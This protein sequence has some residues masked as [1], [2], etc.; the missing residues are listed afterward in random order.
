MANYIPGHLFQISKQQFKLFKSLHH[1][2]SL[3]SGSPKTWLSW[4]KNIDNNMRLAF[5]DSTT[6]SQIQSV[7]SNCLASLS[8]VAMAHY[9]S[10]LN[11]A[12][13]YLLANLYKMSDH[14]L[15]VSH[16]Q[17]YRW[18]SSQLG[19]KFKDSTWFDGLDIIYSL[20]KR[21]V[22]N[23]QLAASTVVPQQP[24]ASTLMPQQPAASTVVPQQPAVSTVVCQ[25]PAVNSAATT[26]VTQTEDAV[27]P[28]LVSVAN[29]TSPQLPDSSRRF[30]MHSGTALLPEDAE[31][32]RLFDEDPNWF[33]SQS[34]SNVPMLQPTVTL[35]IDDAA[36]DRS[37]AAVPIVSSASSEPL[38]SHA[39]SQPP[40]SQI[41]ATLTSFVGGDGGSAVISTQMEKISEQ[42]VS[43]RAD[44]VLL[45]DSNWKNFSPPEALKDSFAIYLFSG[46]ISSA[47]TILDKVNS[48]VHLKK[49]ILCIGCDNF[50]ADVKYILPFIGHI[51]KY[52]N[53][54]FNRCKIFISL[55]GI[56]NSLT[57]N[58][59]LALES[60]NN[61]LRSKL[62]N[63]IFISAP[64]NFELVNNNFSAET[65]ISFYNQVNSFLR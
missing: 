4:M 32:I 22:Q 21:S 23:I 31:L 9:N 25:Q 5:A 41:Q 50:S 48:P 54:K 34:Q 33:S 2:R 15:N 13:E 52:L 65:K 58:N 16:N 56:C 44:T 63:V 27:H 47:K 19:K 11:S 43:T 37:T 6:K 45:G 39:S 30:T 59:K 29:Q 8:S 35:P 49:L 57:A 17:V 7:T 36:G 26:S 55:I 38:P 3:Q 60:L 18:C 1:I 14:Y 51:N 62:S 12:W 24:V 10:S 64:D 28:R 40:N 42:L 46:K 53:S 61:A 20:R